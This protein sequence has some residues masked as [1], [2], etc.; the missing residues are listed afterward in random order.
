MLKA[1]KCRLS[2]RY[3][4][5]KCSNGLLTYFGM[6]KITCFVVNDLQF[7]NVNFTLIHN[8][9]TVSSYKYKGVKCFSEL[10]MYYS[11]TS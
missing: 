6:R 7:I 8:A 1:L 10:L 11:I 3:T 5:R 4:L 9:M 2:A